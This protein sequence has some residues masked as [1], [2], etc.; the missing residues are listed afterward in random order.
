M[1]IC[2]FSNTYPFRQ[3]IYAE[4]S[5]K[6]SIISQYKFPHSALKKRAAWKT[7][8]ISLHQEYI[9]LI[10]WFYYQ[11]KLLPHE[12]I[13][14]PP[15]AS[16]LCPASQLPTT[17]QHVYLPLQQWTTNTFRPRWVTFRWG[18]EKKKEPEQIARDPYHHHLIARNYTACKII[19]RTHC[20]SI[21]FL[22]HLNE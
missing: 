19:S 4:L 5:K 2:K 9:S 17:S 10:I 18:R 6:E 14:F 8:R 11:T 21:T 12:S 22:C 15:K 3:K 13:N 20:T 7:A 1:Y 16:N